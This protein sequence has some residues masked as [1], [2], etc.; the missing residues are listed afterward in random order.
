MD[1]FLTQIAKHKSSCRS[2]FLICQDCLEVMEV[3]SWKSRKIF[4]IRIIIQDDFLDDD[5]NVKNL[6]G[7]NLCFL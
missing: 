7:P 3:P 5:T 1:D 6:S 2:L 4:K